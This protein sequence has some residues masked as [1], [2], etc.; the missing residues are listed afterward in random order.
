[1]NN[2]THFLTC[3]RISLNRRNIE[4]PRTK[5]KHQHTRR[6]NKPGMPYASGEQ[7]ARHEDQIARTWLLYSDV[8]T[9]NTA[10]V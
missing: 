1:M 9:V 8:S 6:Q 4:R 5:R 2:D 3:E 7:P 10:A